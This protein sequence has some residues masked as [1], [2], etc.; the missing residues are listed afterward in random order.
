M[1]EKLT[2]EPV[3]PVTVAEANWAPAVVP[4]VQVVEAL[5]LASVAT[6]V[7]PTEP[8]PAAKVTFVP[9][10]LLPYWSVTFTTIGDPSCAP[11]VPVCGVWASPP[12]T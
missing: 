8:L 1:A 2:G 9:L 10:T 5:P 3:S 4:S 12:E 7:P 11:A 6:G